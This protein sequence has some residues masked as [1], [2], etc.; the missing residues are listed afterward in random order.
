MS[1]THPQGFAAAGVEAGLKNSGGTDVALVV[2]QGPAF[3]GAAV[4]CMNLALGLDETAGLHTV[5]MAP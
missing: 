4:Q 5:G 1:V 3:S 2:N